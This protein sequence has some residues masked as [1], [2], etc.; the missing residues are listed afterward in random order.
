MPVLTYH[1]DVKQGFDFRK[2]ANATVG[3]LTALDIGGTALAVD[4]TTLHD[5]ADPAHGLAAVAVLAT[6]DWDG[7]PTDPIRFTGQLSSENMQQLAA[8]LRSAPASLAVTVEFTVFEYDFQ[9][10]KMF[11]ACHTGGV[12]LHA[13]V[14]RKNGDVALHLSDTPAANPHTPRTF[15]FELAIVP[16]DAGQAVHVASGETLRSIMPW[17]AK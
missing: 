5:P 11:R 2:D 12:A 10:E 9:T 16:A 13:E 8:R 6:L 17:G 4:Q 1:C 14:D 15:Q 3:Y 7:G